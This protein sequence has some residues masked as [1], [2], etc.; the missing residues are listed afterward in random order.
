[1]QHCSHIIDRGCKLFV[2]LQRPELVTTIAAFPDSAKLQSAS[3][4]DLHSQ[5]SGSDSPSSDYSAQ[6]QAVLQPYSEGPL[7]ILGSSPSDGQLGLE[8]LDRGEVTSSTPAPTLTP[9]FSNRLEEEQSHAADSTSIPWTDFDFGNIS[10]LSHEI[11][12][13]SS[14]VRAFFNLQV[15]DM[16][17]RKS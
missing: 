3:E 1:M 14:E 13:A 4:P 6:V 9:E 15:F 10:S 16:F 8:P 2:F 7:R 11:K 5:R 12:I 17:S